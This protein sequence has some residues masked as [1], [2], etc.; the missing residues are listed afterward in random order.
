MILYL[1]GRDNSTAT[2]LCQANIDFYAMQYSL[3]VNVAILVIG[4]VFY[5]LAA[6]WIIEDK[7][8]LERTEA[9]ET[10]VAKNRQENTFSGRGLISR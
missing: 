7:D 4:A 10:Y 5:F 8:R 3:L 9:V 1:R 2:T 6:I